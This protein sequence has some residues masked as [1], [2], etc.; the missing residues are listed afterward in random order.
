MV[1]KEN[2]G[3]GGGGGWNNSGTGYEY[4]IYGSVSKKMKSGYIYKKL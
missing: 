1:K 4:S 3:G 2:G